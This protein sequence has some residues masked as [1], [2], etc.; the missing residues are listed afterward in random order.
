M[1]SVLR[2][3]YFKVLTANGSFLPYLVSSMHRGLA[4]FQLTVVIQIMGFTYSHVI[5]MTVMFRRSSTLSVFH[6]YIIRLDGGREL[7]GTFFPLV[8]RISLQ[9]YR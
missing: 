8:A 4:F 6:L 3:H 2:V 7:D 1:Y 9:A 5:T